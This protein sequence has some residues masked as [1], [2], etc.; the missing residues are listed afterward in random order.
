MTIFNAN[1]GGN[2]NLEL[3]WKNTSPTSSFAA[4]EVNCEAIYD[5]KFF[6]VKLR[7][8]TGNS[9]VINAILTRGAATDIQKVIN[10]TGSSTPTILNRQILAS[11]S[12]YLSFADCV[13]KKYNSTSE[14]AN[15][16]F[17]IHIEIYG[18]KNAR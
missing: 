15:N 9:G 6:I 5:Y 8:S 4:K 13:N 18:I 11:I 17:L 12:G 2:Q 1:V 10:M 14:T 3:I 16:T 7:Q